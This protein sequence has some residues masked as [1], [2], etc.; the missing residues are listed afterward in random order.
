MALPSQ[1]AQDLIQEKLIAAGTVG[2][3][4]D[5]LELLRACTH[6]LMLRVATLNDPRQIHIECY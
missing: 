3:W 5:F 4:C 1:L 2:I 6:Q